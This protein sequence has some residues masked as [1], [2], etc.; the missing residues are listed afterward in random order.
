MNLPSYISLLRG[1]ACLF[2][3]SDSSFW[4]T[5]AISF[6]ALTDFLDGYLARLLNQMTPFG[7]RLDPLMDKLFVIVALA[8]FFGE[9]KIE[10]WQI[11]VF[12]LRDISLIVFTG[13]LWL[14]KRY[15]SWKVRS[16][17]SGK[18]MTTLQF[19]ALIYLAQ[20]QSIPAILWTLLAIC[21]ISS[22]FELIWL[23]L[24]FYAVKK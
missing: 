8:V 19:V 24:P 4:R 20:N 2:F 16:F 3:I 10:T 5:F 12:L 23:S 6:A 17:I 14:T 22:F 1:L 11:V 15:K 9:Q 21:G 13:Y 7:T 18:L